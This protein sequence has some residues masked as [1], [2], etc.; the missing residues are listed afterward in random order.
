MSL[1]KW[2]FIGLVLL[3][4]AEIATFVIIALMIGWFW[5]VLLFV[6]TSVIG[7]MVL[8]RAG[9]GDLDRLRGAVSRD[10]LRA[11]H[12]D[13]PGVASVAGGILLVF[14]GFITDLIGALLLVPPLRRLANA[15][16]SR[17]FKKR[18]ERRDP[19]VIDLTPEEWHQVSERT[20]DDAGRRRRPRRPEGG[21]GRSRTP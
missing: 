12:L 17:A 21:P 15:T 3:P 9:R 16:I 4:A 6:A 7:I 14:P 18:R 8:K 5:A 1:V 19:A 11:L 10:G 13:T 20:L 2:T